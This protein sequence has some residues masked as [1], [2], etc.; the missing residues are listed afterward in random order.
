LKAETQ[1]N[2]YAFLTTDLE[3]C[4]TF[5]KMVET[6]LALGEPDAARRVLKKAEAGYATIR[7]L[8][9][10]L[11]NAD[12]RKEIEE[13]L[14]QLRARLDALDRKLHAPVTP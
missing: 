1:R 11:E 10:K 6:K 8:F 9:P 2:R 14:N 3:V 12:E 13:K 7:R 5:S 4:V